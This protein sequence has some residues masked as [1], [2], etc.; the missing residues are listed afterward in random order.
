MPAWDVSSIRRTR[1]GSGTRAKRRARRSR[2]RSK[3][4]TS[5]GTLQKLLKRFKGLCG[6]GGTLRGNDTIEVQ[7]DHRDRLADALR[8]EGYRVKMSGG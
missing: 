5:R 8:D 4:S 3:R 6:A 2:W 7:G 1:I